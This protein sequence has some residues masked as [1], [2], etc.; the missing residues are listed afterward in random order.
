MVPRFF[1]GAN[2][3]RSPASQICVPV[4]WLS[5]DQQGGP[6]P[7]FLDQFTFS[8]WLLEIWEPPRAKE[9]VEW[10]VDTNEI[11]R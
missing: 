3:P 2:L 11:A 9:S 8:E 6:R 1:V 4:R 7:S 10:F 5:L